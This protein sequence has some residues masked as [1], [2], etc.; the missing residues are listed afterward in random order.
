[1][2]GLAEGDELVV[3]VDSYRRLLT[4]P[5]SLSRHVVAGAGVREGRLRVRFRI[6]RRDS[7]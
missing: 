4:L 7:A 6:D 1:M 2:Q 3:T 5:P